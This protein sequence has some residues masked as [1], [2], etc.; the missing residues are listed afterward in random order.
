M[1]I[2]S[3]QSRRRKT[4]CDAL[5]NR[6]AQTVSLESDDRMQLFI[7]PPVG[8]QTQLEKVAGGLG[9]VSLAI[10]MC[11]VAFQNLFGQSTAL[12]NE[13]KS[14][15]AARLMF[16]TT[17]D[18][19]SW[20]SGPAW[21]S[22]RVT[23]GADGLRPEFSETRSM[24]NRRRIATKSG[25]E[26]LANWRMTP[27]RLRDSGAVVG[28]EMPVILTQ[29]SVE[30]MA[31][32]PGQGPDISEPGPDSADFPDSAFAVPPGVVYIETSLSYSSTKGTPLHDYFTATLVRIGLWKDLELR[33]ATPGFIQE[34]G[35]DGST[36]GFG[37]L[38]FGFKQHI[39]DEVQES[40]LPAFGIIAQVTAPT[41]SAG[42][43][44]GTAIPTL[45]FNFDHT[46]P[47][48]SYFEWNVG[49]SDVHGDDGQRFAQGTFLWSLGHE[50]NDNFTTFFHGLVNVPSGSGE[51]EE[52]LMGPGMIWFVTKRMEL[53]LSFNFGVTDES[54][55]RFARL[56]L[57]VAF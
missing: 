40:G 31:S 2:T 23:L 28:S 39:W 51:G 7:K 47:W 11:L 29:A 5:L 26:S 21:P 13:R 20:L 54:D 57:S 38:T 22:N 35:I 50:W 15:G 1:F 37:P 48:D 43:D 14:P 41:A 33:I 25:Q 9:R 42:F 36:S 27:V 44:D 10:T 19:T 53:D 34:H 55:H 16:R 8:T 4:L 17:E 52:V 6:S 49:I 32:D 45:F 3:L 18:F 24:L 56:G 12:G 30:G 46:L